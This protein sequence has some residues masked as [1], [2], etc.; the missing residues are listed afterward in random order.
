MALSRRVYRS[1]GA[2]SCAKAGIQLDGTHGSVLAVSANWW[3]GLNSRNCTSDKRRARHGA[4][5][6]PGVRRNG[7][8]H[9]QGLV[10][11]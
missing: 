3:N 5:R 6:T 1:L 2:R 4:E 9:P 11:V 8:L 7:R 10:G